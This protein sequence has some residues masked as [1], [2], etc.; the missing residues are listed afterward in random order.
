MYHPIY[1]REITRFVFAFNS[2]QFN[3]VCFNLRFYKYN[4]PFRDETLVGYATKSIQEERQITSA[5]L[6]SNLVAIE[7]ITRDDICQ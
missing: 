5:R 1:K 3:S 4:Q 6:T 7:T 2:I